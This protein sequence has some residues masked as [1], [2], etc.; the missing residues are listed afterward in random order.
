MAR[1]IAQADAEARSRLLAEALR[2]PEV[3]PILRQLKEESERHRRTGPPLSLELAG[4]LVD[5]GRVAGRPDHT[6]LGLLAEGDALHAL[7]R[8]PES[9][10]RYEAAAGAFQSLRDEVGWARTRIGR[11]ITMYRLG[12][13]G[14]A[15]GDVQP[16]RQILLRHQELPRAAVLDLHTAMVYTEFG[17]YDEAL[18][19]LRRAEEAYLSAGPSGERFVPGARA[20]SGCLAHPPGRLRSGRAS[21]VGGSGRLR[22]PG[23]K[24]ICAAGGE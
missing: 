11:L 13:G 21:L 10:D 3:E 9:L 6:A 12:R 17:R 8:F 7:G 4:W 19:C 24:S 2:R 16:A 23:R 18:R 22:A 20:Q 1:L 5:A 14:E 15:L